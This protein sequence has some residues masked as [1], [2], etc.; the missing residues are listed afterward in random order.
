M[1]K[2]A[3]K[4]IRMAAA[5]MESG[6]PFRLD[7][8]RNR[9]E[10]VRKVFDKTILD[11]ARVGAIE[12]YP[13]TPPE[14]ATG[15]SEDFVRQGKEIFGSFSFIESSPEKAESEP[16]DI[17][18]ESV[19]PVLWRHFTYLCNAKEDKDPRKKIIEM[20]EQYNRRGI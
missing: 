2:K 10:M 9:V 18:L 6:Q 12:L 5:S 3:E 17:L 8:I 11:M 14:L 4:Q 16:V 13:A 20:M 15:N 7:R 1:R 19:D